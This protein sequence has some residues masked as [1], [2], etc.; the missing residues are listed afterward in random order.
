MACGVLPVRATTRSI[1]GSVTPMAAV[2]GNNIRKAAAKVS[3]HCHSAVGCA[4]IKPSNQPLTG[5]RPN[6]MT[7]LQTAI[8][9][10]QPAYQRAGSA[11]RAKRRPKAKAPSDKPPKKAAI[12]AST[13]ADSCPSHKADCC[14]QMIW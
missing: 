8:S 1:A 14:V 10:S 9:S 3:D 7:R 4:P 5:A 12:T 11:L 6:V 13:A 2:A